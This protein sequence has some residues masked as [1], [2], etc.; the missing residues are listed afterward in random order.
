M[1]TGKNLFW[2]SYCTKCFL[3]LF[4]STLSCPIFLSYNYL[5]VKASSNVKGSYVKAFFVKSFISYLLSRVFDALLSCITASV[6][7]RGAAVESTEW[8]GPCPLH[9]S[10]CQG[11]WERA[12][13]LSNHDKYGKKRKYS[14]HLTFTSYVTVHL[15]LSLFFV[16][17]FHLFNLLFTNLVLQGAA[18]STATC[19]QLHKRAEKI[20]AVLVERGGVNTGDNVV[21]LY[22]PGTD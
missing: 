21:L 11:K 16:V 19:S 9:A 8:P 15:H 17:L 7:V 10:Q 2:P 13:L 22:P 20:T 3:I 6:S 4:F 5:Y 1:K 14:S 18:V 12:I